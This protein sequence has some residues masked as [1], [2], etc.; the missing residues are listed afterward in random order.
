MHRSRPG[1][2]RLGLAADTVSFAPGRELDGVL[3]VA[4]AERPFLLAVDS[5]QTLRDPS[6]TQ[7]PGG[8]S[9][10]RL[11][12]DALV[13]LAKSQGVVV[14]MTGHVT[15]DG[16]LAG[17][18]ALE[19]AV[20]VVLAFEGDARS[21]YGSWRRARSGNLARRRDDALH[22]APGELTREAIPGRPGLVGGSHR[23]Q[24]RAQP[25]RLAD[26]TAQRE[27]LQLPGL[28]IEHRRH[29]LGGC[30]S[31]PTRLL[32]FAMAGSSS[33]IVERRAGATAAAT[34]SPHSRRGGSGLFYNAART[35]RRSIL[36]SPA[37]AVRAAARAGRRRRAATR[38]WLAARR[39]DL[40]VDDGVAHR[41]PVE[42]E[43]RRDGARQ[44][45][46]AHPR[47]QLRAGLADAP[48]EHAAGDEP[49]APRTI[50]LQ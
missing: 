29:D 17:P 14:V 15:K 9:Q 39:Y 1:P 37:A 35:D 7:M 46:P 42:G 30:T 27:E 22:T 4:A 32:A 28:G 11:C 16:D 50:V 47:P 34:T 20:D 45:G 48:E 41:R 43:D 26:V 5:I 2:H 23:W 12:T 3:Q 8:V 33:A 24:P 25:G 21:G 19:H 13:G 40:L 6:G 31:R 18:R 36:S 10:V 49:Q 38:G 44:E